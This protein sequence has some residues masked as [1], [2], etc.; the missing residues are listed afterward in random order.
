MAK[1]KT[2]K[3][4]V[5]KK[6]VV[7]KAAS[8]KTSK[9]VSK[10]KSTKKS[11]ASAR[12]RSHS[13]AERDARTAEK[14]SGLAQNIVDSVFEGDEPQMDVPVRAASNTNWNAKKRILEM[15]DSVGNRQL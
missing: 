2:T 5:V 14:L 8:K 4:K 9:K 3:K 6:K 11:S 13:R 1:K 7:K 15:G 10:K 12:T